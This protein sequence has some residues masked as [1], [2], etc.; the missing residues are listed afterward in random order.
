MLLKQG[1]AAAGTDFTDERTEPAAQVAS[2]LP[3]E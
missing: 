1:V 3:A 2:L